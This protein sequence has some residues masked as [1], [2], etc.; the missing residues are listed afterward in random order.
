MQNERVKLYKKPSTW[1]LIGVILAFMLLNMGLTKYMYSSQNSY[2]YGGSY[3][4]E[5]M[6]QYQY[7][8]SNYDKD[9]GDYE[10]KYMAEK[11]DYLLTNDIKGQ[12]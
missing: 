6:S 7:Y 8:K 9:P 11:Y 10:S 12:T 1:I 5:Y 2:Q 3:S 4:D